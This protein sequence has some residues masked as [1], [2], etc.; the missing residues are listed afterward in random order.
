MAV[1]S[2]LRI[3]QALLILL[4]CASFRILALCQ[5]RSSWRPT[6]TR[7]DIFVGPGKQRISERSL[8][9]TVK[10]KDTMSNLIR[11]KFAQTRPARFGS[12]AVS[13]GS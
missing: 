7:D 6:E 3:S 12:I 5:S 13:A 8:R 9:W 4:I 1:D 2:N 11:L 10:R